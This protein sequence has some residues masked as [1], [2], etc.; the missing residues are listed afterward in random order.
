MPAAFAAVAA[1]VSA[2]QG[3]IAFWIR[4]AARTVCSSILRSIGWNKFRSRAVA[5]P[6]AANKAQA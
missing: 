5:A 2:V 4:Q 3:A 1:C 6:T